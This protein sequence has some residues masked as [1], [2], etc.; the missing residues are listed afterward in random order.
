[1]AIWLVRGKSV[2]GSTISDTFHMVF[3]AFCPDYW[4]S[5]GCWEMCS[6]CAMWCL[7]D[8]FRI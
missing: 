8:N 7:L 4:G 2:V 6:G 5:M 3:K 1:M